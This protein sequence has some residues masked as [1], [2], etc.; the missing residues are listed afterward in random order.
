MVAFK[1]ILK[2][3]YYVFPSRCRYKTLK[4]IEK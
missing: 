2:V 3:S 1:K 4:C